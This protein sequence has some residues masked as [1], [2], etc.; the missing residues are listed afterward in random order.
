MTNLSIGDIVSRKSYGS[1]VYFKIVDIKNVGGRPV[2]VL[3]GLL[4]RLVADADPDDL[5]KKDPV[6]AYHEVHRQLSSYRK[7]LL[8]PRIPFIFTL[9][10]RL[11]TRPGRILHI[12]SSSDFLARC[13]KYYR[14]EG[15]V[16]VVGK[17]VEESKQP[18]VVRQFLE[19]YNPNILVLTGHDAMKKGTGNTNS[20][21]S[22]RNSKYFVESVKEARKYESNPDKLF[23]FAGA[24]QSYFEA[25]MAEGANFASSPGRI[26]INALDP[27]IVAG[28]V[29]L[30]ESSKMVTP[31]EINELTI[32]GKEGIGGKASKGQMLVMGRMVF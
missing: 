1:D 29:A 18:Q 25:I 7:N 19:R 20:L 12:D 13:T 22:Y 30:T 6:R 23:I 15:A 28:K 10:Q 8:G 11:K 21:D 26:L 16:S 27:S 14:D 17:L 32:S 31:R 3:T 2:F 5:E 24:C 9:L 4:Y